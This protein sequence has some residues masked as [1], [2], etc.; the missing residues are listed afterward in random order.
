MTA[1]VL[2]ASALMAVVRREP[3]A[4]FVRARMAGAAMSTVNASEAVMRS[5]EKGF[6]EEL[7]TMLIAVEGVELV[8]F[9][10]DHALVA[11]RLRPTT[12]HIGLSFADRACLATAMRLGA[13]AVTADRIWATL[14]LPCA[15]ELIR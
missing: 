13:T 9:D 11:A 1:Y 15:I 12:R 3:G 14:D 2:D 10:A 8:P 6:S 5:V 4:D 7:V